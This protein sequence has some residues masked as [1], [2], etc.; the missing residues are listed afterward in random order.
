MLFCDNI[1][2]L[3]ALDIALWLPTYICIGLW[4]PLDVHI[5]LELPIATLYG[6]YCTCPMPRQKIKGTAC[7]TYSVNNRLPTVH[8]VVIV[9]GSYIYLRVKL[10]YTMGQLY[11]WIQV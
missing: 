5:A 11:P 7:S 8:T 4:L 6:L 10:P 1:C 9:Y 2:Q 3:K